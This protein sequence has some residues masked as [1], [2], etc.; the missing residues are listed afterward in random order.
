MVDL[1]GWFDERYR[2]ETPLE[3]ESSDEAADEAADE[4]GPEDP[5]ASPSP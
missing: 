1:H 4:P 3:F 5:D 2:I